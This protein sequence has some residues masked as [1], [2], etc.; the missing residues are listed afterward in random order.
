MRDVVLGE[1]SAAAARI[2]ASASS[3]RYSL[4]DG[5]EDT[6]AVSVTATCAA[7][8]DSADPQAIANFVGT[9]IHGDEVSL[10]TVQLDTEFQL[11]F[12]CGYGAEACYFVGDEEVNYF[13]NPGE[14]F[15]EAFAHNRFPDLSI[16]W[17]Y[18]PALRPT[19]ASLKAVREDTLS[20]WQGRR[21]FTLSGHV[22][23]RGEGAAVES[24]R[25]PL[26]GM[27]SLR[28]SLRRHGYELALRSR[29][30]RLFPQLPPGPRPRPPA[31]LHGLRPAPP[32]PR[33]HLDPRP[34]RPL[35]AASP[36]T[37]R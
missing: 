16:R 27:V 12:D 36:A 26:D 20:P 13:E 29:A 17:R 1:P 24:L 8:C 3:Q 15:A 21:S 10:L 31:R 25:T 33:D 34:R 11:G 23:A 35:P 37:L 5:S 14:A 2:S 7:S 9:L 22:P 18:L 4:G 28:P 30:G 32:A 6:I 19:P